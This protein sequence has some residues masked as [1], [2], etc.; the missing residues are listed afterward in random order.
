MP[1]SL[2]RR[3]AEHKGRGYPD[4]ALRYGPIVRG[5]TDML[6]R[7]G[8]VLEIGANANGLARFAGRRVIAVDIELEQLQAC[9]ASQD[10][11]PVRADI[12][13]LPFR[14]AAFDAVVSVDTYEHLP[15]AARNGATHEILRVL[16]AK[17]TGVVTFP[18]GAA[19][20][21][22]EAT[23]RA[24]YRAYTGNTLRWLE[25]HVEHGLPDADAII[26][27]FRD[28]AGDTRSIALEG[29]AN[30]GVWVW[31]WRVLMCGWPGRGNALA[32]VL[33]LWLTSLL[34][35]WHRAPCYRAMIWIRPKDARR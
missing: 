31:T 23:I 34:A 7:G 5:L 8:P 12:N 24:E 17:G 21:A 25:E 28:A 27:D 2:L 22:A 30:I 29:N 26:A 35:R 1:G 14:D 18:S 6:R 20:V 15:S 16:R 10:V 32:Q 13:A 11:L 9:R 4:W 3:Y 19:A 33:L